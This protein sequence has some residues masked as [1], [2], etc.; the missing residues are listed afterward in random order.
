[1]SVAP[2]Y[3]V[4]QAIAD[5][6][7]RKLL[8]ILS[9]KEMPIAEI[10]KYFP[11]SRTAISK[12]LFILS[13]AHLVKAEKKGREKRFTLHVEPLMELTDWLSYFDQFWDNKLDKLKYLVEKKED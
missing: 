1:M 7:R 9:K 5:P 4:F 12:H 3:D 11:M 10:S 6:T 8:Q 2:K 13:E